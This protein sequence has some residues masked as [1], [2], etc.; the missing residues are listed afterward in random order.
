[1]RHRYYWWTNAGVT[2]GDDTRLRAA[3]QADRGPR[4]HADRH[5]GRWVRRAWIAV[6]RPIFR[7][8]PAGSRTKRASPSWRC[9]IRDAQTGTLHYADPVR[10]AGQENLGVGARRGCADAR[11]ALR[12]QQPVRGDSGRAVRQPGNVQFLGTRRVARLHGVLDSGAQT[13]QASRRQAA[14]A[15][16]YLARKAGALQAQLMATRAIAGAKVRILCGG[17]ALVEEAVAAG[18]GQAVDA[19]RRRRAGRSVPVSIARMEAGKALLEYTEGEIRAAGAESVKLGAQRPPREPAGLARERRVFRIAGRL[20]EGERRVRK[21]LAKNTWEPGGTQ[22]RGP[23]GGRS[24]NASRRRRGCSPSRGRGGALL[25][26]N[27]ARRIGRRRGR[28]AR[29]VRGTRR[30]GVRSRGGDRD[31]RRRWRGR[32]MCRRAWQR[33]G[34]V[35][36]RD[37]RRSR[38]AGGSARAA[39]DAAA[40]KCGTDSGRGAWTPRIP[41]IRFEQVRQGGRAIRNCGSTLRRI[42]SACWRSP[43]LYMHWG[44]YKD[45]LEVLMYHYPP[46]AS[47]APGAWCPMPQDDPL[48]AYYRGYCQR[49]L[50]RSISRRIFGGAAALPVRYVFPNRPGERRSVD[51]RR[52]RRMRATLMRIISWVSGI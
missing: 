28:A 52:S 48:V 43:T 39:G 10:S 12:R 2:L 47:Y 9:T 34:G 40:A 42:R 5:A 21:A 1:M 26:R 14:T 4:A 46:V 37:L 15:V 18:S 7:R 24:C 35:G 49:K 13:R 31:L 25:S 30:Y 33:T 23:A 27:R 45:A 32:A 41:S 19:Q 17:K 3:D 6:F 51:R 16:V 20:R 29:V 44:R 38:D 8:A 11:R 36:L 22:G 50:E